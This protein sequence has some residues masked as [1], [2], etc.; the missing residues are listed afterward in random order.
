M[1]VTLPIFPGDRD[2]QPARVSRS[3]PLVLVVED[4]EDTR[5]MLQTLLEILG[6]RGT[7]AADGESAIDV[8]ETAQPDLILMDARLPLL[9]GLSSTVACAA[10]LP[11]ARFRSLP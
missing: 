1:T 10:C 3:T 2:D 8:A 7:V 11:C 9:D 6:F 5:V 4:H